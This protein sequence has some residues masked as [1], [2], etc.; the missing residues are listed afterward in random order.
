M[1]A[2]CSSWTVRRHLNN[3]KNIHKKR[4]HRPKL[5][6]KNKE[7]RM[8]YARQY[9][10]TSAKEWRKLIFSNEKKFNLDGQEGFQK[11]RHAKYFPEENYSTRHSGGG[12]LMICRG[13]FSSSRKLKLQFVSGQQ[14]AA[15]YVKMQKDLFLAQEEHRLCEEELIVQQDNAASHNASITKKYL[16]EQKIKLPGNP[17][18]SPDLNPIEKLSWLIVAK[19]YEGDQQN[20]AISELKNNVRRMWKILSV[21]LEKLDDCV[22]S[23]IFEV[24]KANS[25][26]QKYQINNLLLFSID[27]LIALIFMSIFF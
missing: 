18:C 21:Q 26:S 19:V 1:D 7:K 15:D 8:E 23:R 27:Q 16:L 6:M 11:Y 14:K 17:A 13:D 22:P 10:T 9:Q 24:I 5:T 12:S 3:N 2:L 25:G 20:S 4:I